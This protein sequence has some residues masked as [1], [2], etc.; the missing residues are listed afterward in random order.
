MNLAPNFIARRLSDVLAASLAL[1]ALAAAPAHA[2]T[3]AGSKVGTALVSANDVQSVIDYL[4][5]KGD[6]MESGKNDAGNPVLTESNN[7]YTVLFYCEDD[8]SK[9]DA[10]EFRACYSDYSEADLEKVNAVSRDYFFGKSY[11]DADGN[12]C[13]ELPIATGVKGIGYEALDLSYEAFLGFTDTAEDYFG[14]SSS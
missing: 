7:Y 11:L 14:P 12:A 1:L 9:C 6:K 4:A 10:I 13:I 3:V 2:A 5:T 8:H